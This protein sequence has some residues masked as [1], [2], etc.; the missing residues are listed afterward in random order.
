MLPARLPNLLIN[1]SSGIAVGI[2]TKIPPHNMGEVRAGG[3][4][5]GREGGAQHGGLI[6]GVWKEGLLAVAPRC[7]PAHPALP[8]HPIPSAAHA[9]VVAGLKALIRN[10]NITVRQLMQHIPGPD[11]PTGAPP[12]GGRARLGSAA[13]HVVPPDRPG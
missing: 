8:H 7:A 11:F 5:R 6:W 10:P 1:G 13:A 2:A 3:W 9:Q 12:L 4:E